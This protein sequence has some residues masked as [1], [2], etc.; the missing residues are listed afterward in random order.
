MK[1]KITDAYF[2]RIGY[3]GPKAA[4]P[5]VLR[6]LH[7]LHPQSIAFENLNPLLGI[8][9]R[10]DAESLHQKMI[11]GGRG[12][13]CFEHNLLFKHMLEALGFKVQGL[14]ARILWN[15]PEGTVTPRGHMLLLVETEGTYY[16][17]DVGF[18]GLTLTSP[19]LLKPEIVQKTP[20]ESYR[21]VRPDEQH[22]IMQAHIRGEWKSLYQFDLNEQFLPDYEVTNWYLSNNPE[23]H[24]VTGLIAAR[25]ENGR[26]YALRGNEL[27]IHHLNGKTEKQVF[28]TIPELRYALEK[29]FLLLI[30]QLP[31]L[32]KTLERLVEQ[33]EAAE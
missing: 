24:F 29:N 12:G 17:A 5:E 27:S 25:S 23:S 10:L 19:L 18:G 14:A 13:Y 2:E 33:K 21:L 4:T 3:E 8:P 6:K 22:Y 11:T 32:D 30:K 1:S 9:V 20:H 15:V 7:E 28:N 16:I 31:G 26:R